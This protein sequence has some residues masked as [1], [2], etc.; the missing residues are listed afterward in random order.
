MGSKSYE[1]ETWF[2]SVPLPKQVMVDPKLG[3]SYDKG[4]KEF[5]AE[6]DG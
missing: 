5:V 2:A 3:W 6:C 4:M 1:H